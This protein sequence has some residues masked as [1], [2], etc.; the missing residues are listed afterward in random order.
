[1]Y[2]VGI[3][4]VM[5]YDCVIGGYFSVKEFENYYCFKKNEWEVFMFNEFDDDM[6]VDFKVVKWGI[7]F[8]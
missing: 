5:L 8:E 6:F 3:I 7:V 4:E 2:F 1:M